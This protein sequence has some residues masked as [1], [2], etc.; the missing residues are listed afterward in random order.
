MARGQPQQPP[1]L[2]PQ[3]WGL[4]AA[5]APSGVT[6]ACTF[7]TSLL[8]W[9]VRTKLPSKPLNTPEKSPAMVPAARGGVSWRGWEW[10]RWDMGTGSGRSGSLPFTSACSGSAAQGRGSPGAWDWGGSGGDGTGSDP[11]AKG[12][13]GFCKAASRSAQALSCGG[14]GEPR[15]T[16]VLPG[17]AGASS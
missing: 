11:A 13:S 9:G 17:G 1:S 2:T 16:P 6:L 14:D 7:K 4:G 5:S 3:S 8:L 15:A 10:L 12:C